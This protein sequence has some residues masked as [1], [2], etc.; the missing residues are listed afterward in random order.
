MSP[1]SMCHHWRQAPPLP[2]QLHVDTQL[3]NNKWTE[4]RLAEDIIRYSSALSSPIQFD[5]SNLMLCQYCAAQAHAPR[6]RIA[7]W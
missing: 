6:D 5:W 2:V 7:T 1:L 3:S 4:V